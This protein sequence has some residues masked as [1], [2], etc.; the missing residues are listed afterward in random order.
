MIKKQ[1]QFIKLIDQ[2]NRNL[3]FEEYGFDFLKE[4]NK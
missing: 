2:E 3:G 4:D 1:R